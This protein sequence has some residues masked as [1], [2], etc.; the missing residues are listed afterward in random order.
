MSATLSFVFLVEFLSLFLSR[1]WE[2]LIHHHLIGH[3]ILLRKLTLTIVRHHTHHCLWVLEHLIWHLT[4][5]SL[6]LLN[7]HS[8]VAHVTWHGHLVLLHLRSCVH[9]ENINTI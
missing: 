3:Q 9:I 8:H 7:V 2:T 4:V 6:H 1:R 5:L